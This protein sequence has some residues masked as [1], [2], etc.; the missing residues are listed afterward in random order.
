MTIIDLG[1]GPEEI[2]K[3]KSKALLQEK[4]NLRGQ[5]NNNLVRRVAEK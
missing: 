2:E 5:K 4:K 1:V 3:R